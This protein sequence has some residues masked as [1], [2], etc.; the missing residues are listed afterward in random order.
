MSVTEVYKCAIILT[1]RA[2]LVTKEVDFLVSLKVQQAKTEG[3]VPSNGEHIEADLSSDGVLQANVRELLFQCSNKVLPHLVLLVEKESK[4][5]NAGHRKNFKV[6]SF[7]GVAKDR[8]TLTLSYSK[9]S[10]RSSCVQFLPTGHT[11][12]RPFLNSINVPL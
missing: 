4:S 6:P 12:M 10:M 1:H 3:L 2:G 8:A 9:N 7:L 5:K 11:L